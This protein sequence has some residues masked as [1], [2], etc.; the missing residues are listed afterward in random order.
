M[1]LVCAQHCTGYISCEIYLDY[2]EGA[3]PLLAS[4]C[5]QL[6]SRK[7][8]WG[9]PCSEGSGTANFWTEEQKRY[10]RQG[11]VGKQAPLCEAPGQQTILCRCRRFRRK[12]KCLTWGG[13]G[14]DLFSIGQ[15][16]SNGHSSR[17]ET[18]RKHYG[19]LTGWWRAKR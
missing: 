13:L 1:H 6:A 2:P 9:E 17:P 18:S 3:N 11:V 12:D 5:S 16:V 14:I 19:G 15:E 4:W 7:L 8:V 10:K